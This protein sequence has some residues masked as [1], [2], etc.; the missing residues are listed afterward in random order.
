[1]IGLIDPPPTFAAAEEQSLN[2]SCRQTSTVVSKN[3][4]KPDN[5]ERSDVTGPPDQL[6]VIN[7]LDQ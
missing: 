7:Y 3:R 1:M 4:Q 6:D 2:E 5:P